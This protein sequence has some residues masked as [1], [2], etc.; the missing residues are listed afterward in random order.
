MNIKIEPGAKVQI[1]DKPI[2]NIFGDVVQNKTVSLGHKPFSQ[3][4]PTEDT[5][6]S[7]D[8][9]Q[10]AI[11]ACKDDGLVWAAAAYA[12]FYRVM[13]QD[14]HDDC[15]RSKFEERMQLLEFHDCT[16]GT[17][18]NA[19][20]NNSFLTSPIEKWPKEEGKNKDRAT[21]L[22]EAFRKALNEAL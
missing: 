13:Q 6:I 17:L 16:C 19:F 20:R 4:P 8:Q 3:Q 22:A 5:T 12:V 11:R 15:S 2:Y 14:Y 18:D 10:S 9:L 7:T 1:T 21:I